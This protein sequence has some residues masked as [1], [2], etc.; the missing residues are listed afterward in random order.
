MRRI[1]LL[2]LLLAACTPTSSDAPTT[3]LHTTA[4]TAGDTTIVT[5]HGMPPV[6]RPDTIVTIWQSDELGQPTALARGD[7]RL[8]VGDRASVHVVPLDGGAAVTLGRRGAGPGEFRSVE[9]VGVQG[10]TVLAW[11]HRLHRLTMF[12]GDG[13]PL[14]TAQLTPPEYFGNRGHELQPLVLRD[15]RLLLLWGELIRVG[16]P[17]RRTL[18]LHDV[19]ADSARVLATW[20]Q[21]VYVPVGPEDA[22]SL[23]TSD[24][25][26]PRAVVAI[27]TDG[28]VA[29]GDGQE[30]CVDVWRPDAAP[31]RRV[32]RDWTRPEV[33]DEI[34]SPDASRLEEPE[35]RR[36]LASMVD[37]Q[38][39]PERMPS[40]ELLG[41]GG[42]G[43]LWVR[44][45]GEAEAH[46][47]P[48]IAR[49]VEGAGPA[50]QR[51]DQFDDDGALVRTVELPTAFFPFVFEADRITGIEELESGELVVAEAR[52]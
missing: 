37:A 8:I 6:V 26:G 17:V 32:C 3:T 42:D 14:G 39:V 16:Q 20:R 22:Q 9:A 41:L 18:V 50:V 46:V 15:G 34:R 28:R 52:L 19:A 13:E 7:G 2:P 4:T 29:S 27:G 45:V 47:H 1:L 44:T 11:D 30:Y 38:E 40:Y 43:T 51:W 21:A 12:G 31:V 48:W 23:A 5:S 49:V 25:F 36:L 35:M 33:G 24:V 10:D